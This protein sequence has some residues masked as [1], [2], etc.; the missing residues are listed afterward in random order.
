ME[1]WPPTF[2]SDCGVV[3]GEAR[4]KFTLGRLVLSDRDSN[5]WTGVRAYVYCAL[6]HRF[7]IY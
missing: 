4:F 2:S 3:V 6:I 7:V 1:G 5:T